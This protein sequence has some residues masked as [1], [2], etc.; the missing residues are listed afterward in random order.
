LL[1]ILKYKYRKVVLPFLAIQLFVLYTYYHVYI[2]S[3]FGKNNFYTWYE[4]LFHL[5]TA[6]I[7]FF[8]IKISIQYL[9]EKLNLILIFLV[10]SFLFLFFNYS[11]YSIFSFI[12]KQRIESYSAIFFD[13]LGMLLLYHLPISGAMC[14][15]YYFRESKEL[16]NTLSE[17]ETE[18]LKLKFKLLQKHLEP[19]FL[20]NNLSVLS[21]L[22]KKNPPEADSFLNEFAD[23]YRYIIKNAEQ[24]VISFK[25]EIEFTK[26]Y[27]SIIE[28]RHGKTYILLIND[29]INV[30]DKLIVPFALQNCIEN[31]IK[32]NAASEDMPLNIE[33]KITSRQIIIKNKITSKNINA[34]TNTGIIN[35][36]SR[37]NLVTNENIIIEDD[38]NNYSITLPLINNLN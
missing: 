28:K 36:K 19:H 37:F 23:L 27:F 25:D 38:G 12:F 3:E 6:V 10:S 14:A 32:H 17:M 24:L 21:A 16:N 13:T 22:I 35:L 4:H 9:K 7:S 31:A 2:I 26:R 15:I 20:F 8:A 18:K 5:I 11:L 33:V 34:S 29:D 1:N 30:T